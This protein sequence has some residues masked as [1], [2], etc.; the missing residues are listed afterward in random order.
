MLN[1]YTFDNI[2]IRHAID[3]AP[4]DK[5]YTMHI[6]EQCEIYFFLS[7]NIEYL[8]E[9][10]KYPLAEN[11]LMIMRPAEAHKAKIL[12]STRYE[13][14]AI[15]FPLSFVHNI[16]PKG[17]LIKAF[18]DRPLGVHNLFCAPEIDTHLV[19]KLFAEMSR[20]DEPYNKQLT[21]KTH[22]LLLLDMIYQSFI[23]R[24]TVKHNPQNVAERIVIYVNNH[25]FEDISVPLL[26]K[27]FFLSP[28]QFSRIFHQAT[29]AA[30]WEY[31][32][33]KRLTAAKEKI[34]NGSLAQDAAETCGFKDY[35]SFYRAYTKHFG[36]APTEYQPQST[37]PS[38]K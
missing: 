14:Y 21:I 17:H 24:G 19:Q 20:E 35:S 16:D 2:Y 8:V 27:H 13:R 34:Q 1:E 23:Q 10:S 3:D 33:K 11:S 7:G 4:N 38:K 29:G 28:S 9:G 30:P 31:I 12:E 26:A 32:T 25:L 15:N 5:Y 22:L 36:C 37:P 6:H 18:T